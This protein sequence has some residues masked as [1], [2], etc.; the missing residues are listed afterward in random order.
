[1]GLDY[2]VVIK[3]GN[4]LFFKKR[5]PTFHVNVWEHKF[6]GRIFE[7]LGLP[8]ESFTDILSG[9]VVR[10][11]KFDFKTEDLK[12]IREALSRPGFQ[13]D[14]IAAIKLVSEEMH[15]FGETPKEIAKRMKGMFKTFQ[16][17]DAV[18]VAEDGATWYFTGCAIRHK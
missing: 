1:M 14:L 7:K 11:F 10:E 5:G 16:D 4:K 17:P 13:Q 18:R 3:K 2:A 8:T 15:P 6:Y 9:V 12:A